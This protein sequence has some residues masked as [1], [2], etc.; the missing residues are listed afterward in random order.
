MYL[1]IKYMFIPPSM[2]ISKLILNPGLDKFVF[3]VISTYLPSHNNAVRTYYISSN[4]S[5]MHNFWWCDLYHEIKTTVVRALCGIQTDVNF[6]QFRF[7]HVG[8]KIQ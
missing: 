6:N 5:M 8:Y 7:H 2:Y 1:F 3:G 4:I